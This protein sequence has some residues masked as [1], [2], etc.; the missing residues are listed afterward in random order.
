M[1]SPTKQQAYSLCTMISISTYGN[2]GGYYCLH[3]P[4]L[5]RQKIS[6]ILLHPFL[7]TNLFVS[8]ILQNQGDMIY[9]QEYFLLHLPLVWYCIMNNVSCTYEW[10]HKDLS[11]VLCKFSFQI[12]RSSNGPTYQVKCTGPSDV[13]NLTLKWG[14]LTLK[15]MRIKSKKK[16]RNRLKMILFISAG[17]RLR[18]IKKL[19][20]NFL[21]R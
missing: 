18:I 11:L 9:I 5:R 4:P 17:V 14:P 6:V 21:N 3:K 20:T 12:F 8:L 1:A 15:L 13:P 16:G 7:N 10:E 2:I 19:A